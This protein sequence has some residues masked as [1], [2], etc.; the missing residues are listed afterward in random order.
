MGLRP[1]PKGWKSCVLSR[2][3]KRGSMVQFFVAF[4]SHTSPPAQ[5]GVHVR[6]ELD[7]RFRGNDERGSDFR[8][9]GEKSRN[10]TGEVV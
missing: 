3:R 1:T 7:Y 10:D 5:A 6:D 4:I 2:T 8:G 9:N